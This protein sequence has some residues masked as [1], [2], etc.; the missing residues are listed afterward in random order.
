[1]LKA[2]YSNGLSSW[3]TGSPLKK[4]I[5]RRPCYEAQECF[6]PVF[7]FAFSVKPTGIELVD[8]DILCMG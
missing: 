2:K 7:Y 5:I 3:S 6:M 8:D 4:A 1:M